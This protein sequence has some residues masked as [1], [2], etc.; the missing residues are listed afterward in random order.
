[1]T[2]EDAG[3]LPVGSAPLPQ[4]FTPE[5]SLEVG[6]GAGSGFGP[7]T[8]LHSCRSLLGDF[9]AL[10]GRIEADF[11]RRWDVAHLGDPMSAHQ[12]DSQHGWPQSV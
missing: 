4:A 3:R 1:M 11:T 6:R 12:Q 10:M 9:L 5:D 2:S 7:A 8:D